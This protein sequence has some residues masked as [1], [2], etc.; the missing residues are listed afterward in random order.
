M[1]RCEVSQV[2]DP[3]GPVGRGTREPAHQGMRGVLIAPGP[4]HDTADEDVASEGIGDS[5]DSSREE[6]LG[7]PDEVVEGFENG[8]TGEDK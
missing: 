3:D 4:R 7:E 2:R 6:E 1:L 5:P 8:P